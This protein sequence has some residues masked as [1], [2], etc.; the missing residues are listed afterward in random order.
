MTTKMEDLGKI[1]WKFTLSPFKLCIDSRST[2]KVF[3]INVKVI[4]LVQNFTRFKVDPFIFAYSIILKVKNANKVNQ[5]QT[6][7]SEQRVFD[8]STLSAF[9]THKRIL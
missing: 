4:I 2:Y 3:H 8:V 5:S 1:H 9:F 6:D 7:T